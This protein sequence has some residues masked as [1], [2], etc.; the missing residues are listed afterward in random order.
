MDLLFLESQGSVKKKKKKLE[1]IPLNYE[2][3][4]FVHFWFVPS[5][6]IH[7]NWLISLVDFCTNFCFHLKR[8]WGR[9]KEWHTSS[10]RGDYCECVVC[11]VAI[12]HKVYKID[13]I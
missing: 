11:A 3:R 1:F 7:F 10:W 12:I 2:H 13:I 5:A 6:K 8:E 9:F 4:T